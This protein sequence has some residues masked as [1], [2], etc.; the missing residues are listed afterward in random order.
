MEEKSLFNKIEESNE[1]GN[2][3]LSKKDKKEILDSY[4]KSEEVITRNIEN[5]RYFI[6]GI[7][8]GIVGSYI[9]T[10]IY[11]ILKDKQFFNFINIL[12]IILFIFVLQKLYFNL[13]DHK[14][15]LKSSKEQMKR[16]ENAD[17]ILVRKKTKALD[18]KEFKQLKNKLKKAKTQQEKEMLVEE[19]FS[20][21]D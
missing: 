2:I 19:A 18:K 1:G 13:F 11:G 12:I 15:I 10:W 7:I 17:S 14:Q 4:I 16:W 8:L 20:P 6:Y 9:S 21:K 3:P 5:L